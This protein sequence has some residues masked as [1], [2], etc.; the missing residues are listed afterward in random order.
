[1]RKP[2]LRSTSALFN[3]K[4]A[5]E[6]D[7]ALKYVHRHRKIN[8]PNYELCLDVA[9]YLAWPAFSCAECNGEGPDDRLLCAVLK[10]VEEGIDPFDERNSPCLFKEYFIPRAGKNP[11]GIG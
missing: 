3:A 1:M 10:R 4:Q 2:G 8:C 6:T 11:H 9:V 5:D 7:D